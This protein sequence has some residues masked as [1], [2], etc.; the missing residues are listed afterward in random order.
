MNF[1]DTAIRKLEGRLI[2]KLERH[3]ASAQTNRAITA[4]VMIAGA[5]FSMVVAGAVVNPSVARADASI[6]TEAQAQS[7]ERLYTQHCAG[8]H[9][10]KLEGSGKF[11]A[12]AGKAFLE[13]CQDNGH[14]VDDLLFIMRSF[15]PYNAPGKLNKQEYADIMAYMLKVNGIAAGTKVL[16]SDAQTKVAL[17]TQ[18]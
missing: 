8:C 5:L 4:G 12:L 17:T 9:G 14:S 10:A 1:I 7:G 18:P 3:V 13:R 11:P 15:M 16:S 6:Y 2:R